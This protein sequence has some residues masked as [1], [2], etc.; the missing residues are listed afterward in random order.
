MSKLRVGVIFGGVSSEYEVSLKSA[1]SVIR[2]IRSDKYEVVCIGITKKGRWLYF[3]G[4]I[5]LIEN[6]QWDKHKD[7]VSAVI[8]PDKTHK[9]LIKL[10]DGDVSILKI[11]VFF[12]VMHGKNGEDGSIQGLLEMSGVPYVG[13]D[14]LSSAACL[15]KETTHIILESY[16]IKT[17]KW[18]TLKT[19]D[20]RN[21]DSVCI[22]VEKELSYPMFVKPAKTG[23]SVGVNK[24]DNINELK[25][26]IKI[27]FSHDDKVIVET[28]IKGKEVE[29]A[30]MGNDAPIASSLGEVVAENS[31]YDYDSKYVNDSAKLLIPA[32]VSEKDTERVKEIAIKAYKALGCSGLTRVD[33]FVCDNGDIYLNE[34]NTLPGFTSISMFPKLFMHDGMEYTEIIDKLIDL[35]IERAE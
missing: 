10:A 22:D 12:P 32:T 21:L 33:F 16:G 35:A 4:D 9:G 15:D 27:A 17:A 7:C 11:D 31:F 25:N 29:C 14:I 18:R 13:C 5:D 28:G 3:P 6:G 30:V 2:N 26:A 34:P 23:S 19:A 24:A 1:A 20:L 8:S